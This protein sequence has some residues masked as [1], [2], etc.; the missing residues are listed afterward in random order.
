MEPRQPVQ[1]RYRQPV[2]VV[3]S[4]NGRYHHVYCNDGTVLQRDTE[5]NKWM[6]A[7]PPLPLSE[8]DFAKRQRPT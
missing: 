5:T 4:Q 8:A 3:V 6:D 2:F 7:G 1:P